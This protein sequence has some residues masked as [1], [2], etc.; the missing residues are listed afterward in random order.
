MQKNKLT[1]K[2]LILILLYAPTEDGA[3]NTPISGRTR[4][5]K[6]GFLFQEEIADQFKKGG[7]LQE[8][9]FQSTSRGNM[10]LFQ[11]PF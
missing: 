2:T 1:G 10:G 6:M 8:A 9:I 7:G 5:M 4:L 11:Q 3:M